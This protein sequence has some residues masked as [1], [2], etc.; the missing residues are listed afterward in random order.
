MMK[1]TFHTIR[2]STKK[3]LAAGLSFLL[4][5]GSVSTPLAQASAFTPFSNPGQDFLSKEEQGF[6]NPHK[7]RQRMENQAAVVREMRQREERQERQKLK[8]IQNVLQNIQDVLQTKFASQEEFQAEV[9][10][11]QRAAAAIFGE[12][13]LFNFVKY[14]DGKK[15]WFKGGQ[16]AKVEGEKITDGRGQ[17]S[18]RDMWDMEYD[19]RGLLVSYRAQS[20]DSQGHSQSITWHGATYT[21]DS[22]AYGGEGTSY[23][24][25]MTGYTEEI[26]DDQGNLK[27]VD[28]RGATYNDSNQL[29]NYT[30]TTTDILGNKSILVWTDGAYDTAGRLTGFNE[31]TTDSDGLT[32]QRSWS[33]GTYE[34]NPSYVDKKKTP[35][36]SE[37]LLTGYHEEVTDSRGQKTVRDW[38]GATYNRFGEIT[39]YTEVTRK[40]IAP[41]S[42]NDGFGGASGQ[43]LTQ[44]VHWTGGQYDDFGRLTEYDEKRVG[45]D[46]LETR[47]HWRNG[48]YDTRGRLTSYNETGFDQNGNRT[49][50][51]WSSFA[52]ATE[53]GGLPPEASAKGGYDHKNRLTSYSETV[54]DARGNSRRK[55]WT[56]EKFDHRGRVLNYTET[57][58]DPNGI[59]KVK[60]WSTDSSGYDIYGQLQH[61]DEIT[62]DQAGNESRVR[63]ENAVYDALGRL[64]EYEETTTDLYGG[65]SH[66]TWKEGTY[67]VLGRVKSYVETRIDPDGNVEIT[68]WSGARYGT[69]GQLLEYH[70]ETTNAFG[71]T[72]FKDWL[73]TEN[74]YNA[75]GELFG[76]TELITYFDGTQVE[77]RRTGAEYD[78]L[79]RLIGYQDDITTTQKFV[80]PAE[81]NLLPT[82]SSGEKNTES[83]VVTRE[84]RLWKG[85]SYDVVGRLNSYEEMVFGENGTQIKKWEGRFNGKGELIGSNEILDNGRGLVTTTTMDAFAFDLRGRATDSRQ[86]QVFSDHPG[87]AVIT[88]TS[89]RIFDRHGQA[90]GGK[91]VVLTVGV[92]AEGRTVHLTQVSELANASY[93]NGALTGYTQNTRTTGTDLNLTWQ[94]FREEKIVSNLTRTGYTEKTTVIPAK[95]G[96]QAS[97]L[98][99]ND[100]GFPIE[101]FGNDGVSVTIVTRT[102]IKRDWQGRVLSYTDLISEPAFAPQTTRASAGKP[103][104]ELQRKVE[105]VATVYSAGGDLASTF[106]RIKTPEGLN[107]VKIM[108]GISQDSR[109]RLAS[110]EER[111]RIVETGEEEIKKRTASTYDALGRLIGTEDEIRTTFQS[112]L[113]PE[114]LAKGDARLV[115]WKA[116]RFDRSGRVSSD[117][118][119]TRKFDDDSMSGEPSSIQESLRNLFSYN[120]RGQISG[121]RERFQDST[122]PDTVVERTVSDL[123]YDVWGQIATSREVAFTQGFDAAGSSVRKGSLNTET[124]R[125]D[126]Q[127]DAF[128]RLI[129][130]R[131]STH[132]TGRAENGDLINHLQVRTRVAAEYDS[133][134]RDRILSYTD[135]LTD[136]ASPGLLTVV[137]REN[138]NFNNRDQI[139]EYKETTRKFLPTPFSG[140][141]RR[142]INSPPNLPVV[143]HGEEYWT[144]TV[145]RTGIVFSD[146]GNVLGYSES[147][148]SSD[149]PDEVN[150]ISWTGTYDDRD[151]LKSSQEESEVY[152]GGARQSR[153][154]TNRTDIS[155]DTQ[156]HLTGYTDSAIRQITL[157]GGSLSEALQ[158]T[159]RRGDMTYNSLQQLTSYRET[160]MRSDSPEIREIYFMQARYDR[161][162]R[163]DRFV[164]QTRQFSE[165]PKFDLTTRVERMG[166][167]YNGFGQVSGM[168]E[169]KTSSDKPTLRVT[170]KTTNITYDAQGRQFSFVLDRTE[171]DT[172][173][174]FQSRNLLTRTLRH[175]T[176]YDSRGRTSGS[177]EDVRTLSIELDV[178]ERVEKREQQYNAWDE[179][180]NAKE[181]RRSSQ[182][183]DKVTEKIFEVR[184]V[185]QHGRATH[186]HETVSSGKY[187]ETRE[188]EKITLNALGQMI[189]YRE[190][191]S[192][193]SDNRPSHTDWKG[194]Y[195][196]FGRLKGFSEDQTKEGSTAINTT[197][198]ES[199]TYD[200]L[201]QVSAYD[202]TSRSSL[203]PDLA[204][205]VTWQAKGT[206]ASG[207]LTGFKET[208]TTSGPGTNIEETR[209]RQATTYLRNGLLNGFTD[210]IT[211]SKSPN[212][213]TLINRSETQYDREGR[214]ST[215]RENEKTRARDGSLDVSTDRQR[216]ASIYNDQNQ[217]IHKTEIGRSDAAPLVAN[218]LTWSGAYNQSGALA[219]Y[220]ETT[221]AVGRDRAGN[222][223]DKTTV[224]AVDSRG[225]DAE[226]RLIHE[227]GS[228]DNGTG[229]IT[230]RRW[231][232][233]GFDARGHLTEETEDF[234][235]RG[236]GLYI[237]SHLRKFDM[238]YDDQGR[239][240]GY[241]ETKSSSADDLE[242][243]TRV[244]GVKYNTNGQRIS[245][246]SEGSTYDLGTGGGLFSKKTSS[247][248]DN[249]SYDTKGRLKGYVDTEIDENTGT[250]TRSTQESAGYN[251]LG[252]EIKNNR[253]I[254]TTGRAVIPAKAGMTTV[255]ETT[256]RTTS[257]TLTFNKLGQAVRTRD[258]SWS[259]AAPDKVDTTVMDEIGYNSAGQ[260]NSFHR[261]AQ[262]THVSNPSLFS[263]FEDEVRT[264]TQYDQSGRVTGT[265]RVV[266]NSD[267]AAVKQDISDTA[268]YNKLGQRT[269]STTKIHRS[270]RDGSLDTHQEQAT[271]NT[272]DRQGRVEGEILVERNSQA[273]GLTNTTRVGYE[274]GAGGLISGKNTTTVSKGNGFYLES[275]SKRSNMAYDNQGQLR[276]YDET[277][278]SSDNPSQ[279]ETVRHES[280]GINGLGQETGYHE[281]S[282]KHGL[283]TTT[284]RKGASY[285]SLGRLTDFTDVIQ[286]PSAI[287][288]T[289]QQ[290]GAEFNLLGQLVNKSQTVTQTGMDQ[291]SGRELNV[292]T[293]NEQKK[294]VYDT[295]GRMKGYSEDVNSSA[296]GNSVRFWAAQGFNEFG[297]ANS[298]RESGLSPQ[299]GSWRRQSDHLA[300]DSSG[301]PVTTHFKGTSTTAGDYDF[302]DTSV[303]PDGTVSYNIFGESTYHKETGTKHGIGAYTKISDSGL[304][305]SYDA[306]GRLEHNQETLTTDAGTNVSDNRTGY[307]SLN[308]VV[309]KKSLGTEEIIGEGRRDSDSIWTGT[310]DTEGRQL[311]FQSNKTS[312]VFNTEGEFVATEQDEQERDGILYGPDGRVK[313]YS[314]S[315]HQK[316]Q[317]PAGKTVKENNQD[318]TRKGMIFNEDGQPTDYEDEGIINGAAY[319]E[320]YKAT[321]FANSGEALVWSRRGTNAATGP[322]Y[323][324][325]TSGEVNDKG[326]MTS[327][328]QSGISGGQ[329][330]EKRASN[331]AYDAMNRVTSM[332]EAGETDA[333]SY[334]NKQSMR[335]DQYGRLAGT[336]ESGTDSQGAY[337]SKSGDY[338]YDAQGRALKKVTA[339]TDALGQTTTINWSAAGSYDPT[340]RLLRTQEQE[341]VVDKNGNRV[342]QGTRIWEAEEIFNDGAN[343]G[344][345]KSS[346]TTSDM[347]KADGSTEKT[348]S[349]RAILSLDAQGFA[350]S[351]VDEVT[352]LGLSAA[353]LKTETHQK[354]TRNNIERYTKED[355]QNSPS[356][357][358]GRI[359]GFDEKLEQSGSESPIYSRKANIKYDE[360]GDETTYDKA[361]LTSSALAKVWD[362]V[363]GILDKIFSTLR[364]ALIPAKTGSVDPSLSTIGSGSDTETLGSGYQL[365]VS[366]RVNG[367]KDSLGRVT[368]WK[369]S[370]RSSASPAKL[371]V[372]EVKVAYKGS[373]SELD[374]YDALTTENVDNFKKTT[375]VTQKDYVYDGGR[376][377][378]TKGHI[379]EQAVD[380]R[381]GLITLNREYDSADQTLNWDSLGRALKTDRIVTNDTAS[382]ALTRHET[383]DLTYDA[384][385]RVAT[386][387]TRTGETGTDSQTGKSLDAWNQAKDEYEYGDN[388]Q[389]IRTKR[390]SSSSQKPA[391][392]TTTLIG[393]SDFDDFGRA[394]TIETERTTQF[395]GRTTTDSSTDKIES[396]SADG[397]AVK[398]TRTTS[399]SPNDGLMTESTEN[400][401]NSFDLFGRVTKTKGNRRQVE[402]ETNENGGVLNRVVTEGNVLSQNTKFNDLGQVVETRRRNESQISIVTDAQGHETNRLIKEDGGF[403]TERLSYNTAGQVDNHQSKAVFGPNAEFA[404]VSNNN[405]YIYDKDGAVVDTLTQTTTRTQG[406]YE[407]TYESR[408]EGSDRDQNGN[409]TNFTRTT[410]N[411]TEAPDLILTE[412]NKGAVYDVRGNLLDADIES[413]ESVRNPD[414][415]RHETEK[416]VHR[417]LD[418]NALGQV[419]D[420]WELD[421]TL[422]AKL[423]SALTEQSND[424]T[425]RTENRPD[426][427]AARQ[428]IEQTFQS[429]LNRLAQ[430]EATA[431][432]PYQDK[433]SALLQEEKNWE[434]LLQMVDLAEA[435][436]KFIG[437]PQTLQKVDPILSQRV[438]SLNHRS[439]DPSQFDSIRQALAETFFNTLNSSLK[440]S[441]ATLGVTKAS[442]PDF[443]LSYGK[444]VDSHGGSWNPIQKV[445]GNVNFNPGKQFGPEPEAPPPSRFD[446]LWKMA[447]QS[448]GSNFNPNPNRGSV[449]LSFLNQVKSAYDGEPRGPGSRLRAVKT[450]IA[451]ER[452]A[453]EEGLTDLKKSFESK[454][455]EAKLERDNKIEEIGH[456][457]EIWT[458]ETQSLEDDIAHQKELLTRYQETGK[459]SWIKEMVYDDHGRVQGQKD[460]NPQTGAWDANTDYTYNRYGQ[461][462]GYTK[463]HGGSET[464][465]SERIEMSYGYDGKLKNT[466]VNTKEILNGLEHITKTSTRV[467]ERDSNGRVKEEEQ[468]VWDSHTP[469]KKDTFLITKK[470]DNTNREVGSSTI[471]GRESK[472]TWTLLGQETVRTT[473]FDSLNRTRTYEK[474]SLR[475]AEPNVK[476]TIKGRAIYGKD[477]QAVGS[478]EIIRR[479][480][481]TLN[482]EQHVVSITTHSDPLK[483]RVEQI[484]LVNG[485]SAQPGKSIL[486]R[487]VTLSGNGL[488]NQ[489]TTKRREVAPGMEI[490]EWTFTDE[491]TFDAQGRLT[492]KTTKI[493]NDN[494]FDLS[495]VV[496]IRLT[497]LTYDAFDRQTGYTEETID[498]T[499]PDQIKILER[500]DMVTDGDG[501][502]YSFTEREKDVVRNVRW[503]TYNENGGVTAQNEIRTWNGTGGGNIQG[504]SS[505][506]TEGQVNLVQQYFY[507]SL[508]RVSGYS[509]S[510][511]GSGVNG[512]MAGLSV[513]GTGANQTFGGYFTL[514]SV[515]N[516]NGF[517]STTRQFHLTSASL[518]Y[519][520][521][522]SN[523]RY[524]SK[525]RVVHYDQI[526]TQYEKTSERYLSSSKSKTS[527]KRKSKER[528][529]AGLVTRTE[530]VDTLEFNS[531]GQAT[532]THT[533]YALSNGDFGWTQ[534]ENMTYD[535]SGRLASATTESWHHT[536]GRQKGKGY[537]VDLHSK[538]DQVFA[539]DAEGKVTTQDTRVEFDRKT[540]SGGRSRNFFSSD[541]GKA[542]KIAIVVTVSVLGSPLAGAFVSLMLEMAL[543]ARAGA[544][545]KQMWQM[546]ALTVAVEGA[547]MGMK[548]AAP[549]GDE[550]TKGVTKNVGEEALKA[551]F[552]KEA[553]KKVAEIAAKTAVGFSILKAGEKIGSQHGQETAAAWLVV[554][555]YLSPQFKATSKGDTPLLKNIGQPFNLQNLNI[556]AT[557][558][559]V[560]LGLLAIEKNNRK[561]GEETT[562]LMAALQQSSG[563]LTNII[564]GSLGAAVGYKVGFAKPGSGSNAPFNEMEKGL[565]RDQTTSLAGRAQ[566]FLKGLF[567]GIL[568]VKESVGNR[569]TDLFK[570]FNF[571]EYLAKSFEPRDQASADAVPAQDGSGF[572]KAK[573]KLEGWLKRGQQNMI[574]HR[575]A[576]AQIKAQ[577]AELRNSIGKM[578]KTLKDLGFSDDQ[579]KAAL[580]SLST[581]PEVKAP[582]LR[583]SL[584]EKKVEA[585]GQALKDEDLT[586]S[587]MGL[588]EFDALDKQ[589]TIA[590]SASLNS[591]EGRG[592]GVSEL[593]SGLTN[594]LRARASGRPTE[595]L[596]ES[597]KA[598]S[599]LLKSLERLI[600]KGVLPSNL[601]KSISGHFR[602]GLEQKSVQDR[603]QL[604][605][606]EESDLARYELR[607]AVQ[608]DA[609]QFGEGVAKGDFLNDE[610]RT[611]KHTAGQIGFGLTP[612]GWAADVRDFEANREKGSNLGMAFSLIGLIP[613]V[614]DGLKIGG[615]S[616]A[617]SLKGVDAAT[618]LV[619][620]GDEIVE[621]GEKIGEQ[622]LKHGNEIANA[623]PKNGLFARISR[624][625]SVE[626]FIKGNGDF[627]R[628]NNEVFV[629][630]FDD[631]KDVKTPSGFADRLSLFEN[632]EGT[633]KR[634]TGN[635]VVVFRKTDISGVATPVNPRL[636]GYGNIGTGIT[637]GGAREWVI[638]NGDI[639]QLRKEGFEIESIYSVDFKGV[640]TEWK[641]AANKDGTYSVVSK[642]MRK[643]IETSKNNGRT[644]TNTSEKL[645]ASHLETTYKDAPAAG[646]YGSIPPERAGKEIS[647]SSQKSLAK[648]PNRNSPTPTSINS[649]AKKA[650]ASAAVLA[651]AGM[652]VSPAA[653]AAPAVQPLP[654]KN[655]PAVALKEL[656][657]VQSQV[658]QEV[659]AQS[660][661]QTA[662]TASLDKTLSPSK[663]RGLKESLALAVAAP[664]KL[665][666]AVI[667]RTLKLMIQLP[668]IGPAFDFATKAAWQLK[669]AILGGMSTL[670]SGDVMDKQELTEDGKFPFDSNLLHVAAIS[671]NGVKNDPDDSILLQKLVTEGF[672]VTDT[673]KISN[674]T[675]FLGLGDATQVLLHELG[676]YDKPVL[677]LVSALRQGIEE[678]GEV[679]VVA[680]SQGTAITTMALELLTAKERSKI[681]YYG[682]GGQFFVDAQV[683]GLASARNV[684]NKGDPVPATGNLINPLN[685]VVEKRFS[686]MFKDR[687]A[688]S[689]GQTSWA[690]INIGEN[691]NKHEFTKFYSAD[692]KAW[693]QEKALDFRQRKMEELNEV[694]KNF[695][696]NIPGS[697][698]DRL[699]TG[700]RGLEPTAALQS[701]NRAQIQDQNRTG[702]L[703]LK[704]KNQKNTGGQ[705]GEKISGFREDQTSVSIQLPGQNYMGHPTGRDGSQGAQSDPRGLQRNEFHA[706]KSGSIEI[707][708]SPVD[709]PSHGLFTS[710]NLRQREPGPEVQPRVRGGDSGGTVGFFAKP[711]SGSNAPFNEME[712]GLTRDQTTSLAG[713]AQDFLKG[714]F[715]GILG[716]KE[717]AATT[718]AK[719][720]GLKETLGLVLA[721]PFKLTGTLITRTMKLITQLPF[722]GPAFDLATKAAWQLKGAIL[723][724]ISTLVSGDVLDKQEYT[725]DGK[726]PFDSNPHKVAAISVNGV[727]NDKED[728]KSMRQAMMNGFEIEKA[729]YITN[730]THLLGF[731]D[732]IQVFLHELGAYDKPVLSLVSAVRQGIEEKGE[733]YV[734]AH[735]QGTAITT[736]ALELLTPEERG[737]IHYYGAGGQFFV[738]AK[739][740][741]LA[742]ARNVWNKGDP[743]PATGNLINPLNLVVENRFSRM[744][745][746]RVEGG[747]GQTTWAEIDVTEKGNK[748][749]FQIFY[750][751]DMETWAQEKA[752]DFRQR[753]MEELNGIE[754]N[755]TDN[756]HG[757]SFDR[758]LTG[759]RRLEPT[760][761]LQPTD[762]ERIQDEDRVGGFQLSRQQE[763]AVIR[764]NQL[765]VSLSGK[766]KTTISNH[767]SGQNYSRNI[768]ARNTIRSDSSEIGGGISRTVYPSLRE[769]HSVSGS[770]LGREN[771]RSI[772]S[773]N[774]RQR[775]PGPEIQ[776]RV[777]GRDSG[778]AVGFFAKAGA[779]MGGLL[780]I[781]VKPFQTILAKLGFGRPSS[782]TRVSA[783]RPGVIEELRMSL[784]SDPARAEEGR[785][786][787]L[788]AAF[789]DAQKSI[790]QT[791]QTLVS[792]KSGVNAVE[793]SAKSMGPMLQRL[794]FDE[795]ESNKI[796]ASFGRVAGLQ[797]I[798]SS[799][800]VMQRSAEEVA[801][802]LE[803]KELGK[804]E[805]AFGAHEGARRTFHKA[806]NEMQN[807]L[808]K[809]VQ[810]NREVREGL[811][812]IL[813]ARME[814]KGREALGKSLQAESQLI[815][816]LLD[817][818]RK[819]LLPASGGGLLLKGMRS[820]LNQTPE[821]MQLARNE[822]I[823]SIGQERKSALDSLV[824][825]TTN[826]RE[827]A[828]QRDASMYTSLMAAVNPLGPV[829][830]TLRVMEKSSGGW[831]GHLAG[832][833]TLMSGEALEAMAL[834]M[835]VI[836]GVQALPVVLDEGV[837]TAGPRLGWSDKTQEIASEWAGKTGTAA[838][839]ASLGLEG[840]KK[841]VA[842]G[843]R[844]LILLAAGEGIDWGSEAAS[845]GLSHR[846]GWDKESETIL[847]Q[848]LAGFAWLLSAKGS[849][850]MAQA[851]L[852]K[853]GIQAKDYRSTLDRADQFKQELQ[854]RRSGAKQQSEIIFKE[855]MNAETKNVNAK[856]DLSLERKLD[857]EVAALRR[858]RANNAPK[859]LGGANGGAGQQLVKGTAQSLL[860]E[861]A[862]GARREIRGLTESQQKSGKEVRRSGTEVQR[863]GTEV[864]RSGTEVQRIDPKIE[865]TRA[866]VRRIDRAM[867]RVDKIRARA[868][869]GIERIDR[870]SR[871]L[872]PL[873]K[874]S[875]LEKP[876]SARS[877]LR[878]PSDRKAAALD[879]KE[880]NALLKEANTLIEK[881][882]GQ[883]K[884][885][886]ASPRSTLLTRSLTAPGVLGAIFLAGSLGFGIHS[887]ADAA[888]GVTAPNGT[889]SGESPT[890][891]SLANRLPKVANYIEE[892]ALNIVEGAVIFGETVTNAIMSKSESTVEKIVDVAIDV[893]RKTVDVAQSMGSGMRDRLETS[894]DLVLLA[895]DT[896]KNFIGAKPGE[897][898]VSHYQDGI[899]KVDMK[900][901]W[902]NVVKP[903]PIQATADVITGVVFGNIRW[904]K[905]ADV[906]AP[907]LARLID[908]K[909]FNLIEVPGVNSEGLSKE[910]LKAIAS[911]LDLKSNQ[912]LVIL[913]SAG[914]EAGAKSMP[915]TH[916]DKSEVFYLVL[917]PR[918]A[919]SRYA[920]Y[921]K[922]GGVPPSQV[923]TVNSKYD[924]PHKADVGVLSHSVFA[925]AVSMLVAMGTGRGSQVIGTLPRF[926]HDYEPVTETG[927]HIFLKEG[928]KLSDRSRRGLGHSGMYEGLANDRKY[929]VEI[930]GK[931]SVCRVSLPDLINEIRRG[932]YQ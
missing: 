727:K 834:L 580:V 688:G 166:T 297:Q 546:F 536:S 409:L 641:I 323:V 639:R 118:R 46:G 579:A 270:T 50:R 260:I 663:P 67:D 391:E 112:G 718:A 45:F 648:T 131:E 429:I 620:R 547:T 388:N 8:S 408:L 507:D 794:G 185:D 456:G 243:S 333:G 416:K 644:F 764:E 402:T 462:T 838:A 570:P 777:R 795:A 221:H 449:K 784:S 407:R 790:P 281:T 277:R 886:F 164:Q 259:S 840:P 835:P 881:A 258:T 805:V 453:A 48:T 86:I 816:S 728:A 523:I 99:S 681:H 801:S 892:R 623:M 21:E 421:H 201:G 915:L 733:V 852:K 4:I 798:L 5:Y 392:E 65:V 500:S 438:N 814:G 537:T 550:V 125:S 532:K 499:T 452:T 253:E 318:Y 759:E 849:E 295:E 502:L 30:Q 525:G 587:E 565:T 653:Q 115:S 712:K 485:D 725:E 471:L 377:V 148:R 327:Y 364:R 811:A 534:Q 616:L 306:W 654:G 476:T 497:N 866:E 17:T 875:D 668:F 853:L 101:T 78:F 371:T 770:D 905:A 47:S 88:D 578:E 529:V 677:N 204:T 162:G 3:A 515:A 664:F 569:L 572:S 627:A 669:G 720:R 867:G 660:A 698:S 332:D 676:A 815:R 522:R 877:L 494:Y 287:K 304:E 713:R 228:T 242:T 188:R 884:P 375:R 349:R 890:M 224:Q 768:T 12:G 800:K 803:A 568:G 474:T 58:V 691:G 383:S 390:T 254:K 434:I 161:V 266:F 51:F 395:Q 443:L 300:F 577:A 248:R 747:D 825:Y 40:T 621:A 526:S 232:A 748:H 925:T 710:D 652:L 360:H 755:F 760:T 717:D 847:N 544:S 482:T 762:R 533:R 511:A 489:S 839:F 695:M 729:S 614:G 690:E 433:L 337:T 501:L 436:E 252:L 325:Q 563:M 381:T 206:N 66:R 80:I 773:H 183:P 209:E 564:G 234:V 860:L 257:E 28:W 716:V 329:F 238:T 743:V 490:H 235:T 328:T 714:L 186:T 1:L 594:V 781:F 22:R 633:V 123:T 64:K 11:R 871:F 686:R 913:H 576:L 154:L 850:K 179:V 372:T 595:K 317:D 84:Q 335:Y 813:R 744:F 411:D 493:F 634:T 566:D 513:A 567:S 582:A 475:A 145:H 263:T 901:D 120:N 190:T 313:G 709:Q 432:Q 910:Q 708:R 749:G 667:T 249:I 20:T 142:G 244:S 299:E 208:R 129:G 758:M 133:E 802:A 68:R 848:R 496:T 175:S 771:S 223:L 527:G 138:L 255:F 726:F 862:K 150:Q 319:T 212:V 517:I 730:G 854:S 356:H 628:G 448:L 343:R 296:L 459:T 561:P 841:V 213:T 401:E 596:S 904:T 742:S 889:S 394:R 177:V 928:Y 900:L 98:S 629:T 719:P 331:I 23:K 174:S 922:A 549:G 736:M 264:E 817:K 214:E 721:A 374:T 573:L 615:K 207:Q 127:F 512:A 722:I 187:V 920:I 122:R 508:G 715:S 200:G 111:T 548:K 806:A 108:T 711:G 697:F 128:G 73:A 353:G 846:A 625:E 558:A 384:Q 767:L 315:T 861:E 539:Y 804:A 746:D 592:Q 442:M 173:L 136:S 119:V 362:G 153:T 146:K 418:I 61:Y 521:R 268:A 309:E 858:I 796:I 642:E 924:F 114:A 812:Q 96:I 170:E 612:P 373:G 809:R 105:R 202:E 868:K 528:D 700:E 766:N 32:T 704:G 217:L 731:G 378:S 478:D 272:Y 314:D 6:F 91:E 72:N 673:V 897:A 229:Q 267:A 602:A 591:L 754:K 463:T 265:Q 316:T 25:L 75:L 918:M 289:V 552:K 524:D 250:L 504:L 18:V 658:K 334:Q 601:H 600:N 631:I 283:T 643:G 199:I 74:D 619:K 651:G 659:N 135:E 339:R 176:T 788:S 604:A 9:E 27:V 211:S 386:R 608:A 412:R 792:L 702:S 480:G 36:L 589:F 227:T 38:T 230:S 137:T 575:Q 275:S 622:L 169:N 454:R 807:T 831:K 222:V 506:W 49:I 672:N 930:N 878:D 132:Q 590:A 160:Q 879:Q 883:A 455:H 810:A 837:K 870:A 298:I 530:S 707:E 451:D 178:T 302:V 107:Q 63:W 121:Y 703:Q 786:L 556:A 269:D 192:S 818:G 820:Q 274:Y 783:P 10:R 344:L 518:R 226:G 389:V 909:M 354:V 491:N 562:W 739:V 898:N 393:S 887:S 856:E 753:R 822:D 273:P 782:P 113:S 734:V 320:T 908:S 855:K 670:V 470:Y 182:S 69:T 923:I 168:T 874:A 912:T 24:K 370:L 197:R 624:A 103:S 165:D 59:A 41:P 419:T 824:W 294:I 685:L 194:E 447:N 196:S 610:D 833:G 785:L 894:K 772:L 657:Q 723:G 488:D 282:T 752:L 241:G 345:L 56:A 427:D 93:E 348:E 398:F 655:G 399:S 437:D 893:S 851:G 324:D 699:L 205:T 487:I 899:A 440:E 430:E 159:T 830:E 76:F 276:G 611:W 682:A 85:T 431:A 417:H 486:D 694:K 33:G 279:I 542:V 468:Q 54:V 35:A 586:K 43:T 97:N 650:A 689:D 617:R 172:F 605:R 233:Q 288:R 435:W 70:E 645:G 903:K 144:E 514:D 538:K 574:G 341:T 94:D 140:E 44:S 891:S 104:S 466:S 423:E 693:S 62:V 559:G 357:R 307:N 117:E 406:G 220:R 191:F 535:Q 330:F 420:Q 863:S 450:R 757:A 292:T 425:K 95:A 134:R 355:Q 29:T 271:S 775:E 845:Q 198:R 516:S 510:T 81:V 385:G 683:W 929:D 376:V 210:E 540:V 791:A 827:E 460:W 584:L 278:A 885:T 109:G 326:Q 665:V 916:R 732:A 180:I 424:L 149:R 2:K 290:S 311:S 779:I 387:N 921:M 291:K 102:G 585:I 151:R 365:D 740:W 630:A 184:A 543:M 637:A 473:S 42:P 599:G 618:E 735:S 467:L 469:D 808:L 158:T 31:T 380:T 310:Y 14:A 171:N 484:R 464:K 60:T 100:T 638:P 679:Y 606:A 465:K 7:I 361:T 410:L 724:G 366:Q 787:K 869:I 919:P 687:V 593:W 479:Q 413:I 90:S 914:T 609:R 926:W 368:E 351:T 581:T 286:D 895:G 163:L 141:A 193:S 37:Y 167:V 477:G 872:T 369:E 239:P 53:D 680:H 745:Q 882:F 301:R 776:P 367:Q 603:I 303:K 865:A 336:L 26:T 876:L 236:E 189:G 842:W 666:G 152:V 647:I 789:Q 560:K 363:T 555:N 280:D 632:F 495:K 13:G 551:E 498:S 415:S 737:K 571:K 359:S 396:F 613:F 19:N 859:Q 312:E 110:F 931:I 880:K 92:D 143:Q 696:D 346:K 793:K 83:I 545:P 216:T 503:T 761:T 765:G 181:T 597:I 321:K 352:T 322:T 89:N 678:K 844:S 34:K 662:A 656:T 246:S 457:E 829:D 520:L 251:D 195:D 106:E 285:D 139:T 756:N 481:K 684:W 446:L 911:N 541:F 55:D 472:G 864:Q 245:E 780:S 308:Q 751:D 483:N 819:G 635:T 403:T 247:L 82:P 799:W 826:V 531:F 797:H 379:H 505:E 71:E 763:K 823:L 79:G 439:P 896:V 116:N 607:L 906:A 932:K 598:E 888:R 519:E 397:Q 231:E 646:N 661:K 649:T 509:I 124:V 215:F 240:N 358:A 77:R 350:A 293:K 218:H 155:Y 557:M 404:A 902:I 219:S 927:T 492:S 774:L 256:V 738:D 750:S 405:S 674:G 157:Q 39:S 461:S 626:E 458:A 917:S 147:R 203:T 347:T 130:F 400:L 843:M 821:R 15:V 57:N 692:M 340:G 422:L 428:P 741:G 444:T 832:W 342:S 16:V 671:V 640:R 553:M 237:E 583:L 305:D 225:F 414:G 636:R 284:T 338:E 907:K 382:P 778:G 554:L 836:K 828:K 441:A 426:F 857:Q 701:T 769:N 261:S 588:Y 445:F 873:D 126:A 262:S 156:D 87:I 52:K 705:I 675:H 706:P